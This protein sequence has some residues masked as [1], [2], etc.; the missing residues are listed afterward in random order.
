[1]NNEKPSA[2]IPMFTANCIQ[3]LNWLSCEDDSH[4]NGAVILC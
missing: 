2:F 1:M 3:A 4:S